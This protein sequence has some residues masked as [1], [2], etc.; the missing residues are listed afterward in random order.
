MVQL[1]TPESQLTSSG[2]MVYGVFYL[3][4]AVEKSLLAETHHFD[5][6]KVLTPETRSSLM[7]TLCKPGSD[8]YTECGWATRLLSARSISAGMLQNI[9]AYNLNAQAMDATIELIQGV[10]DRGVNV[11]EVYI[12]TIGTPITYQKKLEKIFPS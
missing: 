11:T 10:L 9:G 6:S 4:L 8:L 7:Q 2:P 5:D 12:D 3:P 1:S